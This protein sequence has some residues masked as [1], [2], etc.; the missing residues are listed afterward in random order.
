MGT[1]RRKAKRNEEKVALR[2][3]AAIR[4]LDVRGALPPSELVKGKGGACKTMDVS[5][6]T[7]MKKP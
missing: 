4:E 2:K 5:Q 1:K 3:K 6:I 7:D